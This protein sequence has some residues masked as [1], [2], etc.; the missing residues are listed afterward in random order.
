MLQAAMSFGFES[1]RVYGHPTP[2][3]RGDTQLVEH[4]LQ[5]QVRLSKADQWGKGG[6]HLYGSSRDK[7]CP[8]RALEQY[9][10]KACLPDSPPPC[11]SVPIQEWLTTDCQGLSGL[12]TLPPSQDGYQ[13]WVVQHPQLPHRCSYSCC[14]GRVLCNH[15]NAAGRLAEQGVPN[16]YPSFPYPPLSRSR[17]GKGLVP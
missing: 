6:S 3:S 13:S 11:L 7:C 1:G 17:D 14:Q 12:A 15:D 8:V 9:L 4:V 16:V 10:R 5:I 2:L